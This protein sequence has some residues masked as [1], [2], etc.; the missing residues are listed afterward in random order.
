MATVSPAPM[1]TLDSSIS[2]PLPVTVTVTVYNAAGALVLNT[3]LAIVPPVADVSLV[4][5]FAVATPTDAAPKAVAP[6]VK[7]A[8]S[9]SPDV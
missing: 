8:T 9:T 1:M 6:K 4:I 5:A 7:V 3:A 2:P